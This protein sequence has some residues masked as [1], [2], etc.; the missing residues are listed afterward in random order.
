MIKRIR[1][2]GLRR[3][4]ESGDGRGLPANHLMKIRL[5]LSVLD[6]VSRIESINLPNCRLHGLKGDRK[7]DWSLR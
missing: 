7:G 5:I 4:F 3:Y 6:S 1:H 2:K